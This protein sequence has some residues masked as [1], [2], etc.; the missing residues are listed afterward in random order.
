MPRQELPIANG[1]YE[2]K[3]LPI[4]H[5]RCINWYPNIVQ[6][7]G[8]GQQGLFGGA[9]VVQ[10]QTTGAFEQ[11]NRGGHVKNGIDYKVNGT[12]LYRL[13]RL[14]DS[15]GVESF[16]TDNLGEIPGEGRVSMADNGIELMILVPGGDG[17]IFN[18][19][20]GPAFEIISDSGF[21]ANGNPQIVVFVDGFFLVTTDSK[22]FIISN[23]NQGLVWNALDFGT[24]EADPDIIVAPLIHKNQVY[25]GGSETLETFQNIGGSGFPFQ[26]VSGGVLQK[27]V[28]APFSIV[29]ASDTFFFVGGGTNESPAIWTLS[30]ANLQKVSTTAIDNVLQQ[31]TAEELRQV[32]AYSYAQAGAY[33]VCF[34]LPKT[35]FQLNTITQRWNERK[36]QIVDEL[37]NTSTER[38]RVNSIETAYGKLIVGDSVDGRIGFLDL[39]VFTEYGNEIIRTVST[40]PFANLG[41]VFFVPV[42]ELTVESGNGN[43]EVPNPVM[44]MSISDNGKTFSGSRTRP[45]G[46]RGKFGRRLIWY[47]NGRASRLDVFEFTMSDAANPTIIKL[48]ADIKVGTNA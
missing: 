14:I 28:F 5:Q 24:A 9:G 21:K 13:N 20:A 3:S 15:E 27:G 23:L 40:Q 4:S 16:T 11:I 33:F 10:L 30:G 31:L 43:N 37:D 12:S 18:E 39:D 48:E 26:R 19:S 41:N 2:S 45:M 6:T 29:N 44:R 17:F 42:I 47:K 35:L 46:K 36:S 32:F 34:A 1:F 7:T 8:L 38:W 22:K 25:I